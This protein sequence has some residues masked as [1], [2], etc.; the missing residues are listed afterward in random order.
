MKKI[1]PVQMEKE[2]EIIREVYNTGRFNYLNGKYGRRFEK[3]FAGF[4]NSEYAV[5]CNSG[6]NALIL[7]LRALDLPPGSEVITTPMTFVS[8]VHAIIFSGLTPHIADTGKNTPGLDSASI[9][10]CINSNTSAVL[11]VHIF[12]FPCDMTSITGLCKRH[13]L[14]IVEDCAQAL[15]SSINGKYC[16]TFGDAGAFSFCFTKILT[17]AGEGGMVL[18]GDEKTA[19]RMASMRNVGYDHE[20][21]DQ[22]LRVTEKGISTGYNMRMLEIQS[23]LGIYKLGIIKDEF[24]KIRDAVK[25]IKQ[26]IDGIHWLSCFR[27]GT[28]WE[29]VYHQFPVLIDRKKISI[30]PQELVCMLKE[31]GIPADTAYNRPINEYEFFRRY[32]SARETGIKAPV[33]DLPNFRELTSRLFV[34]KLSSGIDPEMAGILYE[35]LREIEKNA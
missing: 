31:R 4:F 8:T 14:K 18:T 2:L 22:M 26:V 17:L 15:G 1:D 3:C 30:S 33:A 21:E 11:P 5:S 35:I 27:E 13:G 7:A 25:N 19:L 23:A 10:T 16:G 6:T 32:I 20:Y 28:G 12:G 24:A 34:L 9:E 29:T